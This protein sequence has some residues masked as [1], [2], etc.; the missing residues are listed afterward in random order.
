MISC[1]PV[2]NNKLIVLNIPIELLKYDIYAV[3]P[4]ITGIGIKK[5]EPLVETSDDKK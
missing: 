1:Q 3:M 5:R 4:I 2:L